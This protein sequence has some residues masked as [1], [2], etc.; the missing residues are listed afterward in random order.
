MIQ[1][2]NEAIQGIAKAASCVHTMP[3]GTKADQNRITTQNERIKNEYL[4]V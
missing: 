3:A 4:V 2:V 1:A